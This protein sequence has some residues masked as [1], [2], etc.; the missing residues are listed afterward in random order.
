MK[1]PIWPVDD[2]EVWKKEVAQ[3][4]ALIK[5]QEKQAKVDEKTKRDWAIDKAKIKAELA[6]LRQQHQEKF[7]TKK[8]KGRKPKE[9]RPATID[10][11]RVPRQHRL[12]QTK[13]ID[14]YIK[15]GK[16]DS[17]IIASVK[18]KIPAYP[19]EKLPKLV[20]LRRYHTKVK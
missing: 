14:S 11:S 17:E 6:D 13:L 20:K 16:S 7:G 4:G 1:E 15:E 3:A 12:G 9:K 19:S 5:N 2:I 10:H 8:K 18:E